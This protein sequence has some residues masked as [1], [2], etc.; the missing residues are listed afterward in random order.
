[1]RSTRTTDSRTRRRSVLAFDDSGFMS[2]GAALKFV[3]CWTCWRTCPS[4]CGSGLH[5]VSWVQVV[6]ILVLFRILQFDGPFLY[7]LVTRTFDWSSASRATSSLTGSPAVTA[8]PKSA[9]GTLTGRAHYCSNTVAY[10]VTITLTK[11]V[12]LCDWP[13]LWMLHLSSLRNAVLSVAT[14]LCFIQTP[15]GSAVFI[16]A[17]VIMWSDLQPVTWSERDVL[18]QVP[19]HMWFIEYGVLTSDSFTIL[20]SST[21][22]YLTLTSIQV[23]QEGGQY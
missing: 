23:W 17:N 14:G 7:M 8:S 5:S 19:R 22:F 6:I 2:S 4:N 16:R 1:M 15:L 3:I 11:V 18:G 9:G 21:S 13:Q 12:L 10:S 20:D